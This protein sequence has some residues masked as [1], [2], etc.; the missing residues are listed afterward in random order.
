[1]SKENSINLE[2]SRFDS[3]PK[4]NVANSDADIAVSD[5]RLP[6]GLQSFE[7]IRRERNL[8]VDK[9]GFVY[10]LVHSSTPFFL[11]RPRRFG[12]SLLLSTI[13]AYWEGKKDLFNGLMIGELEARN[14]YQ[15]NAYPVFHFDF[16]GGNYQDD[17]AL[18]DILDE[19]LRQ[20]EQKYG[21]PSEGDLG[22][23]FRHLIS[24]VKAKT[25]LGVVILVDEY[26]KPLLDSI[27]NKDLQEKNKALFR[28]FFSTLKSYDEY[29][30]FIF[31][32]GVT[33]F[34]KVSIFSDL[35]QLND[36]SMNDE[37]SAI[38]GITDSELLKNFG[39]EIRA[40][41]LK[42]GLS[43][44]A[45]LDAL[46]KQYDGY[47]FHYSGP[48]LYNPFSLLKAFFEKDLG[49]Y[50]FETGTPLFLVRKLRDEQFDVA[51]IINSTLY[52]TEGDLTNYNGEEFNT[53]PLLFQT[54][55]LTI[56]DYDRNGREYTLGFPN[57]E[58]RFGFLEGLMYEYA[59]G[60]SS[61]SGK[62]IFTLSRYLEHGDTDGIKNVFIAL[63]AS[64][65]YP[66]GE[67]L[68]EHYFQSIVFIV[69]T[70]LSKRAV[71]ELHTSL[72]R[73]DCVVECKRFVYI[74]EFKIDSGADAAVAQIEEKHYAD[75]YASD[76]RRIIKI[77]ASFSSA[78]RNLVDWKVE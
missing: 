40:L 28:S 60:S 22:E 54:G 30:Q 26:D 36:I 20:W 34:H 69:F 72:G 76:R 50:W 45:C 77:G 3:I 51:S 24:G 14:N 46:K 43:Y 25:G 39:P 48:G 42:Q 18:E 1:M 57:N 67:K 65:P 74:F 62:D 41:A 38:C 49:S 59:P 58:V 31:I 4:D 63:F 19:H 15:W 5:R 55:Y 33:K 70:L 52:A 56:V 16:N 75:P 64:L 71:C 27:E 32:T 6:V 44:E 13:K 9:T 78:Q 10:K 29:I 53:I 2:L 23:R 35:N 66:S 68:A 8:Y 21:I 47:K 61:G 11:S 37:Y 12:K 17:H 73:I 7:K